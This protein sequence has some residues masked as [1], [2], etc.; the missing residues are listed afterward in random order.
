MIDIYVVCMVESGITLVPK[1]SGAEST[2]YARG[3]QPNPSRRPA[4]REGVLIPET[5]LTSPSTVGLVARSAGRIGITSTRQP[6]MINKKRVQLL[7]DE[8][9]TTKLRRGS[10]AMHTI[11]DNG[12]SERFCPLGIACEVARKHRC[13]VKI[14]EP[15]EDSIEVLYDGRT[16]FM[17]ESVREWYGFDEDNPL[18]DDDENRVT[19]YNDQ[20]NVSFKQMA[21]LIE[22]RYLGK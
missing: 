20:L 5:T 2:L 10:C 4:W 8:L 9:R 14:R 15:E 17:P 21:R 6:L 22:R 3:N 19:Y 12:G 16:L 18:L 11:C 7:V 1:P 13:K